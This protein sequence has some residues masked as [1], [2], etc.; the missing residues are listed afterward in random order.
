MSTV[1]KTPKQTVALLL[2]KQSTSQVITEAKSIVQHMTGNATFPSPNPALTTVST[3]IAALEASLAQSLTRVKGAS[4]QTKADRKIVEGSLKTLAGYVENIANQTPDTAVTVI[5]SAGMQAKKHTQRNPKL[6]TVK[7]GATPG[8]VLVDSKAQRG[9]SYIYQFATDQTLAGGWT[10]GYK[11][12]KVK[13]SIIG[14]TPGTRY[15]FRLATV[16]NKGESAWSS[17]V[18]LV[19]N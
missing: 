15:F 10:D 18:S 13:G 5:N 19:V 2:S 3:Q 17:I 7:Q 1:K 6:F 14:L 4:T 8:V 11:N 16:S 12:T 9:G